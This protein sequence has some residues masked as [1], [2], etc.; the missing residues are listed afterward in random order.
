MDKAGKASSP[1]NRVS[2]NATVSRRSVVRLACCRRGSR[3]NPAMRGMALV[4]N[5]GDAQER[6][7]LQTPRLPLYFVL[8]AFSCLALIFATQASSSDGARIPGS[9]PKPAERCTSDIRGTTKWVHDL[10]KGLWVK[11][12][13]VCHLARITVCRWVLQA[14]T[15]KP[16]FRKQ[17]PNGTWYIPAGWHKD[18]HLVWL[19]MKE[20]G[21]C[22]YIWPTWHYKPLRLR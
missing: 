4:S 6:L 15:H 10:Q 1:D 8:V 19:P 20:G 11:W 16:Y 9:W 21:R 5:I 22:F 3:R 17:L 12:R 2:L 18:L 14:V 13:C 7:P